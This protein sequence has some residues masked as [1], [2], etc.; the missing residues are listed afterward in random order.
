VQRLRQVVLGLDTYHATLA[1]ATTRPDFDAQ[2]LDSPAVVALPSFIRAD[3]KV[4]TS[5]DTLRASVATFRAQVDREPEWLAPDGQRQAGIGHY[6]DLSSAVLGVALF[7]IG[8]LFEALYG[9]E[10]HGGAQTRS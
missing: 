1:P 5:L 6:L 8:Y 9:R 7:L 4:L 2:L 3:L 10:A